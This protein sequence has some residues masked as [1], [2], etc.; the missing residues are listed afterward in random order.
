MSESEEHSNLVVILRSYIADRFCHGD[1]DR[2]FTD[3]D[4]I[5]SLDHPPSIA[6]YIP[7]AY[8]LLDEHGKVAIG[9]AKSF[10]DLENSHTEA[11]IT[12]FL[13]RCEMA[14]GSAFI[15]A[16]PWPIE[17]LA[18]ALLTNLRVRAGLHH[19]DTVV[20]SEANRMGAAP[21]PGRYIHCRS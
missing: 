10:R 12:A 9:E 18:R 2:V 17:R 5:N 8:V 1:S 15:L 6:G 7:D 13:E 14:K 19:V 16:V 3:S 11:Q 20:L 21:S 4:R